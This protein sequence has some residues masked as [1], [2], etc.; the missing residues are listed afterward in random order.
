MDSTNT[1]A[2]SF[3]V[4]YGGPLLP[5]LL[6]EA[7]EISRLVRD[8]IPRERKSAISLFIGSPGVV[9]T[10][11]FDNHHNWYIVVS[12]TKEFLFARPRDAARF[13]IFPSAHPHA[14]Q[15]QTHYDDDPRSDLIVPT[16]R[17]IVRP[18]DLLFIPPGWIHHVRSG[19]SSLQLAISVT[20]QSLETLVFNRMVSGGRLVSESS[21]VGP[22]PFV[23][24]LGGTWGFRRITSALEIFLGQIEDDL[25]ATSAFEDL[26][27]VA[28]SPSVR[29]DL[30]IPK[31]GREDRFPC[32]ASSE[33]V[34][35]TQ[36]RDLVADTA[37]D[38]SSWFLS[39]FS[40]SARRGHYL[41]AYLE[42]VLGKLGGAPPMTA[43]LHFFEDCVLRKG[44]RR[45]SP[46]R[47]PE[48]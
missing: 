44:T 2:R 19:T 20:A 27:R 43:G 9:S 31:S 38:V 13:R 25:N 5:G 40:V 30:G 41:G 28:Y 26:V 34:L 46:R 29:I 32:V 8:H 47:S 35:S 16:I 33:T 21:R 22:L 37:R 42:T 15:G 12:G 11:H 6:R 14:R 7:P 45:R 24:L 4:R 17:A 1:S 10:A 23:P 48:L 3:Y 36:E 18:G 39:T